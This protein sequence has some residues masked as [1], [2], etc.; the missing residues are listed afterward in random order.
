MLGTKQVY[1]GRYEPEMLLKLIVAEK[2][3]F[4]HCVPTIMHMLVSSPAVKQVDLSRWK[5]VIG[6]SALPKGLCRGGAR[7]A[8]TSTPATACRKPARC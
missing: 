3:T 7:S 4:S 6:G 1:P 5:V 8:S 2:V